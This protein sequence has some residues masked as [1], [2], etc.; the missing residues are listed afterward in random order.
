MSE[1][2][3]QKQL[4]E[5]LG[6]PKTFA[7]E[8]RSARGPQTTSVLCSRSAFPSLAGVRRNV[9]IEITFLSRVPFRFTPVRTMEKV[10]HRVSPWCGALNRGPVTTVGSAVDE[11]QGGDIAAG[12]LYGFD[13]GRQCSAWRK[14][15]VRVSVLCKR[16]DG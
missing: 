16:L 15:S 14:G 6:E 13:P 1:A 9:H 2:A 8:T 7:A 12:R 4:K 5:T 3:R 10:M 11:F